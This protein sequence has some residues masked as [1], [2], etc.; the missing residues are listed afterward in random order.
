MT[1]AAA[2]W[3]RAAARSRSQRSRLRARDK[4]S[5]AYDRDFLLLGSKRNCVLTLDEVERYGVESY[6]DAHYVSI[7][8]LRPHAWFAEGVRLLGRTAVECTRD[9]LADEIGRD[10]AAAARSAPGHDRALVIDPFAGSGNTLY[11]IHRHVTGARGIGFELDAAVF[12]LTAGNVAALELPIE[13]EQAEYTAGLRSIR[14]SEK[15][16]LISFIAPPWGMA[17][18][19]AAGL[20]LRRTV[21]P[22]IDVVDALVDAFPHHSML[23]A[24]QVHERVVPESLREVESRFAW[25]RQCLYELNAP[26]QN[27]GILLG[28]RGWVPRDTSPATSRE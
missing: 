9:R 24:V 5:P 17:L 21:P 22:I 23:C 3:G 1:N 19:V 2:H 10:V 26:G 14:A 16:L 8:G 18:D 15:Q 27:H 12:R 28:T 13:I 20:D 25:T 11:W 7:Y 6:G 4:E